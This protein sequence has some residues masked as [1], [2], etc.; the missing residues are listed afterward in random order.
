MMMMINGSKSPSLIVILIWYVLGFPNLDAQV[1]DFQ[2]VWEGSL[3]KDFKSGVDAG[4]SLE[5]RFREN[6]LLYDRTQTTL[7]AA[8]TIGKGIGISA[9]ARW[10]LLRD[11]HLEL[12]N[13]F[14]IHAAL[15]YKAGIS[16]F[17]VS[18][19][20]MVQHGF[21]EQV[22]REEPGNIKVYDRNRVELGYHFFGTKWSV[23]G[24]YEL[25]TLLFNHEGILFCRSKT[26][27]S[28]SYDINSRNCLKF[29]YLYDHEFN[30]SDP[31]SAHMPGL[32]YSYKF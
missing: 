16:S 10:I 6:S 18:L 13:R 31:Q 8:Y 19:R 17:S 27:L 14:R 12:G 1:T 7:E 11:T 26:T 9:G 32:S 15:S 23:E 21:D 28:M 2:T 24:G 4:L 3:E 29:N 22:L 30:Q 25:Y 20:S 5:Q